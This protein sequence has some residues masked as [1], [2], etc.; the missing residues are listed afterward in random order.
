MSAM[1]KEKSH[2]CLLKFNISIKIPFPTLN[3]LSSMVN[4]EFVNACLQSSFSKLS[5]T[6]P[7]SQLILQSFRR[8]TYVIA[9]SPTLP[10]LHLRIYIFQVF[11]GRVNIQ[12]IIDARNEWVWMIMMAKWYSGTWGPKASRH[13]S[14]RW[15]KT[16]KKPHP[17]NLSRPG[18]EPG[19]AALQARML[20]LAPQRFTYV[21]IHSPTHLSLLLRHKFFT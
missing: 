17:G 10:L 3:V 8:I 19:P 12:Q 9:H 15:G 13:L 1:D 4:E 16:P 20:P 21:T 18:I 11:L 6:S 7:T 2:V 14:Y 5:V